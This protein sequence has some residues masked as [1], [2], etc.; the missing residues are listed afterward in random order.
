MTANKNQKKPTKMMKAETGTVKSCKYCGDTATHV[1]IKKN[2]QYACESC[3]EVVAAFI[4]GLSGYE[5]VI[6]PIGEE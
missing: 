4:D 6:V 1:I 2:N 5:G 3:S